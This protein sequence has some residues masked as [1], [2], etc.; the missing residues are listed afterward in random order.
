MPIGLPE[1]TGAGG[2]GAEPAARQMLTKRRSSVFTIASRPAIYADE[3]IEPRREAYRRTNEVALKTSE[4]PRKIS[5]QAFGIFPKIRELDQILRSNPQLPGR[6]F[7]SHP[8]L[9]FHALNSGVE[10]QHPKLV[11]EGVE[12]RLHVLSRHGLQPEFLNAPLRKGAKVDDFLDACALLLIAERIACN[13]A[14]S[15]PNPPGRDSFGLPIAIW[16]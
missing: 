2:R 1:R 4:P 13:E 15:Y 9:A 12:E 11:P 7:E 5:I 14:T 6:I 16:A 3:N 8:E 10:M